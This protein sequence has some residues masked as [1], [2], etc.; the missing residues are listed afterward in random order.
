METNVYM[1][2]VVLNPTQKAKHDDGAVP[3]IIVQPTAVIARDQQTA[4]MKAA[5]LVPQEYA[6]KVDQL[7]VKIVPFTAVAR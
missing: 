3:T 6:D 2:C 1:V 5:R 7:E 4:A